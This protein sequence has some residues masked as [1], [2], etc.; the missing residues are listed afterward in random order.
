M[1]SLS[2]N[3]RKV[4]YLRSQESRNIITLLFS[5]SFAGSQ[6]SCISS[7]YIFSRREDCMAD[8]S[9]GEQS[10]WQLHSSRLSCKPYCLWA[11]SLI[12]ITIWSLLLE[13]SCFSRSLHFHCHCYWL[14]AHQ[15][16]V[17]SN[18]GVPFRFFC[19]LPPF[20]SEG[21]GGAS[22]T[23][24]LWDLPSTSALPN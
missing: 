24:I 8:I 16:L 19:S 10:S 7:S 4:G 5:S 9:M 2:L 21:G 14:V 11:G 1:V 17:L 22:T 23:G 13:A 18:T 12:S 20:S 15:R 3:C 6:G